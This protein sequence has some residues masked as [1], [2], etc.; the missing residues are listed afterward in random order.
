METETA[1][2]GGAATTLTRRS[3]AGG[4]AQARADEADAVLLG[5]VGGLQYDTLDRRDCARSEA[6]LAH[7]QAELN[8]FANLRPAILYP[9][10]GLGL[11]AQAGGRGRA[12]PA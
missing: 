4:D 2:V 8:L 12:R 9:R 10:A 1:P 3:A 11:D 7:A 5:A 6:L